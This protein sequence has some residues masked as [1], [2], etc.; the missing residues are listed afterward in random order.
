MTKFALFKCR[1]RSRL[2]LAREYDFIYSEE[3][4]EP[5]QAQNLKQKQCR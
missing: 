5:K 4:R 1:E 3:K 2:P